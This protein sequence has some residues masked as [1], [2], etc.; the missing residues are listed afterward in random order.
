MSAVRSIL[1]DSGC[2]GAMKEGAGQLNGLREM[3]GLR[4]SE[5]RLQQRQGNAVG[6][7]GWTGNGKGVMVSRE[8]GRL[9]DSGLT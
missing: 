7:S 5:E 6:K 3:K 2:T 4:E 1:G 9:P 8:S